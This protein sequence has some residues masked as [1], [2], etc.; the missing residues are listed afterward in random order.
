MGLLRLRQG[1]RDD[2]AIAI[3][4]MALSLALFGLGALIV[5]IG[6]AR[7]LRQ[8]AVTSADAA[9]LAGAAELGACTGS[10]CT[11]AVDAVK[12]SAARNF[13]DDSEPPLDWAACRATPPAGWTWRQRRSGSP[14]IQFGRVG[15]GAG[16]DP[17]V[18]FV[19]MPPRRSP[20]AFGGIA[21]YEGV[22]V[23]A[24]AVAGTETLPAP[25]CAVCVLGSLDVDLLGRVSVSGG[26]SLYATDATANAGV[27][28]VVGAGIYLTN[29]GG[30]PS[31]SPVP[32]ITGQQVVDPFRGSA[33]PSRGTGPPRNKGCG[34]ATAVLDPG[35]YRNLTL[36]GA[37]TLR[38]GIYAF[39]SDLLVGPGASLE[40]SGVTLIFEN[41]TSLLVRGGTVRLAAPAAGETLSLFFPGTDQS[42]SVVETGGL[43]DV[44]GGIYGAKHELQVRAG[45]LT[46]RGPVVFDKVVVLS[47]TVLVQS[48]GAGSSQSGPQ[49]LALVR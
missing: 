5:D 36:A 27:V 30:G 31:Y 47:G 29:P 7:D 6:L 39:S 9:A 2:G 42:S 35:K 40:G 18:V 32:A 48:A 46:T 15:P 17:S 22:D 13:Q 38:P 1:R 11:A 12:T 43:L 10:R 34:G 44:D 37:C 3:V 49:E 23:S 14:C 16:G 33:G 45:T 21:G 41:K 20:A 28:G 26:G 25:P 24:D 19:R 4:V 8:R